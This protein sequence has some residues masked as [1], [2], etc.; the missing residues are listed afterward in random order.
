M[1]VADAMTKIVRGVN[2]RS[3]VWQAARMMKEYEVG[4]LPVIQDERPI[5]VL[6]DR[7]LVVRAMA[8]GEE[9]ENLLVDDI[10]STDLA[11]IGSEDLLE[12]AI[13]LMWHRHLCRL[14]VTHP[15]SELQ[16]V[17]SIADV[18]SIADHERIGEL[19]QVLGSS[20][21]LSHATAEARSRRSS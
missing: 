8:R 18:A 16:G 12:K 14:L 2:V 1:K 3:S 15:G 17:L 6:T 19:M 11:Y 20:H 13:E 21:W 4:F 7:D 5:G 9:F 10:M